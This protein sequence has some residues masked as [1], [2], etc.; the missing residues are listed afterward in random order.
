M[1]KR[2]SEAIRTCCER[3]KLCEMETD[4]ALCMQNGEQPEGVK[5][6]TSF[7]FGE[8]ILPRISECSKYFPKLVIFLSNWV[9]NIKIFL[10]RSEPSPQP[11]AG[12]SSD[13][14]PTDVPAVQ[15]QENDDVVLSS[16]DEGDDT[17][18]ASPGAGGSEELQQDETTVRMES[19]NAEDVVRAQPP[20]AVSTPQ[21]ST[22]G[23]VRIVPTPL[24][25]TS[26]VT[27]S[28]G[29]TSYGDSVF[30]HLKVLENNYVK[31]LR[32]VYG[33]LKSANAVHV[34]YIMDLDKQRKVAVARVKKYYDLMHRIKDRLKNLKRFD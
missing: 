32:Q 10:E 6:Q 30:D 19:N 27:T 18:A 15:Q 24:P 26:A 28:G 1:L 3:L 8:S 25:G 12:A 5:I 7:N 17:V 16:E 29:S 23:T 21:P 20:R 33:N 9:L 13:P 34:R 2:K 22:S 31:G 4:Q 14:D 11:L